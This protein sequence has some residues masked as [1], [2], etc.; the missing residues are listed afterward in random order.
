MSGARQLAER[1][2]FDLSLYLVTDPEQPG[3][4]GLIPVVRAALVGGITMLQLR[5]KDADDASYLETACA[6]APL[7]RAA[8]IPFLLNDRPHL[9]EA[10]D[11]DGVH[12]G[13]DDVPPAEARAMTG[14]DRILGL[15]VETPALAAAIDPGLVDYAGIGP[16]AAT[17]TKT[18]HKPPLGVEGMSAARAAC[19]V[20]AVGIGGV[21]ASNA[22][23]VLG[24]GVEGIAVV[25]AICAAEDPEAAAAALLATVAQHRKGRGA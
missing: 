10:A 3:P 1:R 17:T 19:P 16:F 2:S 22:A 6:L 20:P 25:S 23:A 4:R 5:D 13:Q 14:P 18:D 12:I 11:A 24:T 21:G 9:V 8:G 15:S 7:A